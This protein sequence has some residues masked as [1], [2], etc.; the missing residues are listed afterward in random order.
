MYISHLLCANPTITLLKLA[1][2][3][4]GGL[5]LYQ[6]FALQYNHFYWQDFLNLP[7]NCTRLISLHN[8]RF[9]VLMNPHCICQSDI[10]VV[11]P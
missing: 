8:L 3:N 9:I 4:L 5:D 1:K 2:K 10:L 6:Y 11:D 7:K